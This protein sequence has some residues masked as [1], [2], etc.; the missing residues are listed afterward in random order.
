MV[1][2]GFTP[3]QAIT[4]ATSNTAALLKLDDR[5]SVAIGKLADLVVLNADPSVDIANT[6]RFTQS[7][8]AER[9]RRGPWRRSRPELFSSAPFVQLG[10]RPRKLFA[11]VHESGIGTQRY[12][13]RDHQ[14][15]PLLREQSGSASGG[16]HP[17]GPSCCSPAALVVERHPLQCSSLQDLDVTTVLVATCPRR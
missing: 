9:R 2:A 15:S 4:I 5:G 7:G 17:H 1:E 6:R 13:P 3:L 10:A 16:G 12:S 8:T 14:P 11:A